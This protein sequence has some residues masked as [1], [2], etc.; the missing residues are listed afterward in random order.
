MRFMSAEDIHQRRH[1]AR[2]V[3]AAPLLLSRPQRFSPFYGSECRDNATFRNQEQFINA[4]TVQRRHL[5]ETLQQ[6]RR[7]ARQR[8][9]DAPLRIEQ[10][11]PNA[12][13]KFNYSWH[14]PV[15]QTETC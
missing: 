1:A 4:V 10:N 6:C 8:R 2:H 15:V 9:Q 14:T 5:C 13:Q 11:L 7:A 12:V 3:V